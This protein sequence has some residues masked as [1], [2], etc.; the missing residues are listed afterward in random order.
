[1]ESIAPSARAATIARCA[2]KRCECSRLAEDVG[3]LCTPCLYAVTMRQECPKEEPPRVEP[4]MPFPKQPPSSSLKWFAAD[5]IKPQRVEFA[6]GHRIVLRTLNLIVGNEGAGKGLLACWLA[7][8]AT[9]GRLLGR[10]V[11]VG[12]CSTEEQIDRVVRPR[13]EAA[14]ADLPKVKI[15]S[16]GSLG[17]PES[18]PDLAASAKT[19]GMEWLLLDPINAHFSSGYNT[20]KSQD[21]NRVL[22]AIAGMA[23]EAGLTVVGNL[24]T[25]RGGG[26]S[27]RERYAHQLEFRRVTRSAVIIGQTP[28]DDR[29][30]RTIVHDKHNY[31]EENPALR[32][33]IKT[34]TLLTDDGPAD[35]PL[36]VLG[37]E[38]DATT[39]ELF[40]GEADRDA[41]I[42]EAKMGRTR[43][44]QCAQEITS[45][46][47]RAGKPST[48]DASA[49][50]QITTTYG[51]STLD[52]A[53][54]SLGIKAEQ[55]KDPITGKVTGWA[56]RFNK[57]LGI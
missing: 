38:T 41:A 24:H 21:V 17:L 40:I 2:C 48:M 33:S 47:T 27:A 3:R 10:P 23:D 49:F 28:D 14:G 51:G 12:Y 52:R 6:W 20:L 56:W 11:V 57:E 5:E 53:K 46:W 1:M 44:A 32:A 16:M 7:A 39:A 42:E 31:S 55:A 54:R 22:L 50:A 26:V 19:L 18:I 30:Q 37:E 35:F 15:L 4:P 13:L 36:L 8:E 25:N 43:R 45:V 29:D 9:T 34:A